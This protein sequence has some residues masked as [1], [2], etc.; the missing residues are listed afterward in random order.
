MHRE[1]EISNLR[2]R[3]RRLEA[4]YTS[5]GCLA[6]EFLRLNGAEEVCH[7]PATTLMQSLQGLNTLEPGDAMSR[8]LEERIDDLEALK[9]ATVRRYVRCL[10]DETEEQARERCGIQQSAENVGFILRPIVDPVEVSHA[11]A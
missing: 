3:L 8:L 2:G 11:V 6:C 7:H 1:P 9:P 5:E 10:P 4:N